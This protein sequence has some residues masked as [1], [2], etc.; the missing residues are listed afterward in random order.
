MKTISDLKNKENAP[1]SVQPKG[2]VAALGMFDGVHIGH[3]MLIETAVRLGKKFGLEP[4][5]FTFSNH[6][7]SFFGK[8]VKRI[9][10]NEERAR[11]IKNLG[12]E[13]VVE[14]PFDEK[15]KDTSPEKFLDMLSEKVSAKIF[16]AG[17][18]YTFGKN[19]LGTAETLSFLADERGLK[20][21]IIPPVI[22]EGEPVSSTRIKKLLEEGNIE[23]ANIQLGREFS[24]KGKVLPGKKLGR[25]LDFPTA[26]LL[27]DPAL[28]LPEQGVYI[29]RAETTDGN[30]F[31]AITNVGTGPTVGD[32]QL[33]IET[34][35][36]G[37]D[38]DIYGEE[39][40][41][42]F[43]KRLRPVIK[44]DSVTELKAQLSRDALKA[45]EYFGGVEK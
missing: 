24:I 19:K 12:A 37:F 2:T 5:V 21:C 1:E 7:Q 40:T 14:I 25:L 39:L 43:I 30:C 35:I 27:P 34:N 11:L 36:L 3:K 4:V 23:G 45:E 31:P 18:D 26:N 22:T 9:C 20:A 16:V 8:T 10:T 42:K 15:I 17:F 38:K 28:V 44:F 13:R 29:T 32:A 6:P 33:R 41:V